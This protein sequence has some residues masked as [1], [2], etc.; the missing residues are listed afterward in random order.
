LAGT[1]IE[2]NALST[3]EIVAYQV[4]LQ[5]KDSTGLKAKFE[6]LARLTRS[7]PGGPVKRKADVKMVVVEGELDLG[8][9]GRFPVKR[10]YFP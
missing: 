8:G 5:G 9:A 2:T 10:T 7:V 3:A 6:G 1:L 4:S